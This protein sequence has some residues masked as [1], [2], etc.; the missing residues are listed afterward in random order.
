VNIN[1]VQGNPFQP[2]VSYRGFVASH[3]AGTPVGLSVFQDGVRVNEAFGDTVNWDLMPRFA[4]DRIELVPGSNPLFGLNTLGGALTVRTKN[5]FTHQGTRFQGEAGSFDRHSAELTHG[6]SA[7]NFDWFVGG[8]LFEEQG[9]RNYSRSTVKQGFM[10]VGW[11]NE[12]TDID[13]SYTYA[14]NSLTGNGAAPA[15]MLA[16]NWSAVYVHPEITKPRLNFLTLKLKHSFTHDLEFTGNTYYRRLDV[17]LYAGDNTLGDNGAGGFILAPTVNQTATHTDGL[18]GTGQLA[19]LGKLAG[20]ANNAVLGFDYARGST[21]FSQF[22]QIGLQPDITG[23]VFPD[24]A[25]PSV[26]QTGLKTGNTYYGGYLTDTFSATPWLHFTGSG[27]WNYAN[28]NLS[29]WGTTQDQ[30]GDPLI[31]SLNGNHS[32]SRFN[33]AGGFTLQP[34]DALGINHAQ[35]D[36]LTAFG[37]YSEGFRVPSPA[38]LACANPSQPCALPTNYTSDPDLKPVVSH[39]Y[40]FGLR[41]RV[42]KQVKWNATWYRIDVDNEILYNNAPGSTTQ[43]YFQN[44]ASTRRQG[45]ETGLT[46]AW[47]QLQWFANYS[48][49]DATFQTNALLQNSVGPVSVQTGD[50]MPNVPSQLVKAGFDVE[51]LKD[52]R[53]GTDLQYVGSQH[54]LNDGAQSYPQVPEYVVLNLNTKYKVHKNL[55]LYAMVRNLTDNHYYTYGLANRSGL[56]NPVGNPTTFLSPGAPIGGW[57]GFRVM[58]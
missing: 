28:V 5:G 50:K 55:E 47:E 45:L 12:K 31:T 6:G 27:R 32:F 25:F 19:Y 18:G 35:L 30:N 21:N 49:I 17:G 56:T 43:G 22:Q 33:P 20:F 7:G 40:E 44:I 16:Q 48:I 41:G 9:W 10:K 52:W 11:D 1:E 15:D 39:T 46:G 24:P 29:G 36:D 23:A 42:A 53:V 37:N 8:N 54:Y 51:L 26:Q 13:L 2:D 57:A 14:E 34:L 58:F 3:L 38:E 4:I